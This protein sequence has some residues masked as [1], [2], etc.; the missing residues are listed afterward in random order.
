M[1]TTRLRLFAYGLTVALAAPVAAQVTTLDAAASYKLGAAPTVNVQQ[2]LPSDP[3]D[4]LTFPSAG[5]N[6]AGI[7]TYGSSSGSFGS[8]SSGAGIYN[9]NGS[10]HIVQTVT[11]T[12]SSTQLATFN[13]DISP[14]FISNNL[15]AALTGGQ[16]LSAG[17]SFAITR[18]GNPI[19][20]SA[21]TLT[22]NSGGTTFTSSGDTSLYG[23]S[24]T[25]Y[26]INGVTKS[27]ALGLLGAGQSLVLD[28]TLSSFANGNTVP[29][30]PNPLGPQLLFV[31]GQFVLGNGVPVAFINGHIVDVGPQNP[32]GVGGSHASSGD[33][34][35]INFTGNPVFS[36][37]AAPTSANVVLSAVPEAATWALMIA[38]FGATGATLR[39][40]RAQAATRRSSNAVASLA[41][42][43]RPNR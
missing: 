4:V 14:G 2:S 7:H 10:F 38:G 33:P 3:V 42:I 8:R 1:T 32:S 29:G 36:G 24:G 15:G 18:D 34:F 28:Y 13:F 26:F 37:I 43:G 11:N 17:L 21:A 16:F 30:A 6:S 39:R 27:I 9:V 22:T 5:N 35:D 19:Y 23:G 12:G 20:N 40:R 41:G 25:Y 31:P